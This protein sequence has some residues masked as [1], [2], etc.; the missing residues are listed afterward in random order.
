[1][2]LDNTGECSILNI[3]FNVHD[4]FYLFGHFFDKL[5]RKYFQYKN[6]LG[7]NSQSLKKLKFLFI[8]NPS[9]LNSLNNNKNKNKNSNNNNSI[10]RNTRNNRNNKNNDRGHARYGRKRGRKKRQYKMVHKNKLQNAK[11]KQFGNNDIGI[12]DYYDGV[13]QPKL[14]TAPAPRCAPMFGK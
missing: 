11:F 7:C 3:N 2:L 12:K 6:Q 9:S 5:F 4:E 8:D 13:V 14:V 10:N 1:M